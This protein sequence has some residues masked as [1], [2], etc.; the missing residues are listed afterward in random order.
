MNTTPPEK[1]K[2]PENLLQL[3]VFIPIIWV[4]RGE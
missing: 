4:V 2:K 3:S 1:T